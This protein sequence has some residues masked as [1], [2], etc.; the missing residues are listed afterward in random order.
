MIRT[1]LG[2]VVGASLFGSASAASIPSLYWSEA[3]GVV[4]SLLDGSQVTPVAPGFEVGGLALD[5]AHDRLFFTDILPLGGP[6]PG[7]VIRAGDSDGQGVESIV[8]L[9]QAPTALTIDR[10]SERVI[11]SDRDDRTISIATYGGGEVKTILPFTE[12]IS[13][14]AGLAFDPWQHKVYFSYVNPLIDS[15]TPGAIARMNLDGSEL[16]T[17]VSGLVAPQGIAV[18]YVRE[19]VYWADQLAL[20]AG[21]IN[22]AKY[23]GSER[24]KNVTEVTA[25]RGVAFDPFS[26][27]LYWTDNATG[28]IHT[29]TPLVEI[30]DLVSDR[31]SP[32]AIGLLLHS[33][34]AGD[35]NDD[36]QVDLADLNNV[37]NNFG[38]T[39][40]SLGDADLDGDVDLDDL[41]DV[42]NN[43]GTRF[44][45]PES[46]ARVPEPGTS[47]LG[48]IGLLGVAAMAQRARK[49]PTSV[50]R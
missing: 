41:N 36:G 29:Q 22:S 10:V 38:A 7:G 13:D 9:L 17:V 16:E 1:L 43:F 25:P 14:I 3:G 40:T 27:Q 30:V 24:Q 31:R 15:L 35:T 4:S 28:K 26:N 47:A 23:D 6:Q 45:P 48:F 49:A 33:G 11:W 20:M 5:R 46:V 44:I 34:V 37:R 42:R 50:R 18:D 8:N 32:V 39:D 12:S 21:I 2:L 19:R